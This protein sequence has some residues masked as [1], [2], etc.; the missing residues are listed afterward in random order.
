MV[1]FGGTHGDETMGMEV[2]KVLL[3]VFG[4]HDVWGSATQES[5]LIQGDLYLGIGNPEA[6]KRGTRSVSGVRD[7][8][9]C[10]HEA[11]FESPEALALPDQQR[12]AEL[13]DLLARAD[14]F[15]DL[16]SVSTKQ[17][18]PFVGVTTFSAAHREICRYIPVRYIVDVNSILGQDVGIPRKMVEQ[19]PTTC[20][21]VNRHGGVGLC[22]EMGYQNDIASVPYAL[23]VVVHLLEHVGVVDERFHQIFSFSSDQNFIVSEQQVYRLV[24]CERNKFKNFHYADSRYTTSFLP[25]KTGELIGTYQ[26]KEEVRAYAD[27]LLVFP[28]GPQTLRDNKSLFYLATLVV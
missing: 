16:H 23:C 10:F 15:F 3:G 13:K 8:N 18:V 17:T 25:V 20:S 1:V 5:E 6:V 21:W 2:V 4:I 14:Y 19:T 28:S 11:F 12:A 7:L 22:Y 24:H 9:R 27:G 26:D